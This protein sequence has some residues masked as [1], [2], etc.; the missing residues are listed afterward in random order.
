MNGHMTLHARRLPWLP[1]VLFLAAF[2]F[3]LAF[4]RYNV[5]DMVEGWVIADEGHQVYQPLRWMDGQWF[6]RDYSTNNYPPG[7]IWLHAALF[8]LFGVKMSVIRVFLAGVGAGI[9]AMSFVV[10]RKVMPV[11]WAFLAYLLCLSWNVL[12][13]N[14]GYP[15]WY[16]ALL[17]LLAL[18]AVWRYT[19][20]DTVG[21][22][23]LAGALAG[24]SLLFKT[25]QGA[26]QWGALALFLGWR[27]AAR[28]RA[29]GADGRLQACRYGLEGFVAV[30]M[31]LAAAFLIRSFP[32]G[33]NLLVFGLP[34]LLASG[35]V[36]FGLPRAEAGNR[37]RPRSYLAELLWLGLGLIVVTA[38]WVLP[39]I[40]NVG[41]KA[42]IDGTLLAP[43][44]HSAFMYA[45]IKLPERNGWWLLA[46]AASGGVGLLAR[47]RIRA[48]EMLA[49]AAL[50][51][52][53]LCIPPAFTLAPREW[54]RTGFHTWR[55]L[56]FYL[57]PLSS[58]AL[59]GML[60]A[61]RVRESQG[62]FLVLL[63]MYGTWNFMQVYPFADS[64]HLLW[65]I[66]PAFIALAYLAYRFW[67]GVLA[68]ARGKAGRWGGAAAA[69]ALSSLLVALQLYALV[70]HFYAV[71]GGLSRVPY[72]LLDGERA[73]V[74]VREDAARELRAVRT[75]IQA[76]TE[77]NDTIFDTSGSFFY[78]YTDRR[79]PTRHD[80]LWPGFLTAEEI[81][82]LIRDLESRRPAL[83]IGRE[84]DEHVSGYS[85]FAETFPTVAAFIESHY[86]REVTLGSYVL[87]SLK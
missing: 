41:W 3:F 44:R 26:F 35:A 38:A 33:V 20:G 1:A 39:T 54:L 83:I 40:L 72:L 17:G 18:W 69:V 15:S 67:D 73:D 5:W 68:R 55:D 6:Y 85:S 37:D 66:Q 7:G 32:T 71:D 30:A 36:L 65:S 53:L 87:W 79:N 16:C 76:R 82:Q 43:L 34:V 60:W 13:L 75:A 61:N 77:A 48:G 70:G 78:F 9:A 52:V 24:A 62:A 51:A 58:V 64:N 29:V 8:S 46:W 63:L 42:F 4:C 47:R 86:Q 31:L 84:T 19:H 28:R 11:G 21:W 27:S 45:A 10:A 59:W 74:Y 2:A 56:R 23:V 12:N 81:E 22:L 25:T 49:F 57:W 14:I 50:G 80:F